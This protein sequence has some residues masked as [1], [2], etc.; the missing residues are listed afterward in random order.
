M[1]ERKVWS[2][3]FWGFE[4]ARGNRLVQEWYDEQPD[5]VRDEALDTIGYLQHSSISEW[6]RPRFD[7]LEDGISEIRFKAEGK[8][9]RIYGCFW[10]EGSRQFYTFLH[11]TDKKVS[12]DTHG[13]GIAK[14]NFGK[15]RRKEATT[16][17][18]EFEKRPDRK[19]EQE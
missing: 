3:T 2:W 6:K 12:N 8:T 5:G 1:T 11:A 15:L 19:A 13:K 14:D 17:Q 4:T 16:H 18:F 10:P 7:S 9:Y